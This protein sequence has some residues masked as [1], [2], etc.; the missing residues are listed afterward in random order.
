VLVAV[1]LL[2]LTVL[3][4]LAKPNQTAAVAGIPTP[5]WADTA[6]GKIIANAQEEVASGNDEHNFINPSV[7]ADNAGTSFALFY[8]DSNQGKLK[9]QKFNAAGVRQWGN[10]GHDLQDSPGTGFFYA[11][12]DVS[13]GFFVAWVDGAPFP[14]AIHVNAAG[15]KTWGP[16][17]LSSGGGP[18]TGSLQTQVGF[19]GEA[20]KTIA[21]DGAGGF[22]FGWWSSNTGSYCGQRVD[23]NGSIHT[24]WADGVVLNANP[25]NGA[26]PQVVTDGAGG[27]IFAF[28]NTHPNFGTSNVM[29][30]HVDGDGVTQCGTGSF[31]APFPEQQNQFNGEEAVRLAPDGVG[32]AFVGWN[33]DVAGSDNHAYIQ[34]ID[35]DCVPTSPWGASTQLD[36]PLVIARSGDPLVHI[37]AADQLTIAAP[38][39]VSVTVDSTAGFP[40]FGDIKIGTTTFTY[41]SIDPTHF[42]LLAPPTFSGNDND[43]VE[44]VGKAIGTL[45]C[46][47][48]LADMVT[49]GEGG[50]VV[51]W[52]DGHNVDPR[53]QRV[54]A[55]GNELWAG[56]GPQEGVMVQGGCCSNRLPT[57][58][59]V[60]PGAASGDFLAVWQHDDFPVVRRFDRTTGVGEVDE[61]PLFGSGSFQTYSGA[62]PNGSGG[63]VAVARYGDCCVQW[64]IKVSSATSDGTRLW[65]SNGHIATAVTL[66]NRGQNQPLTATDASGNTFLVWGDG[67][68]NNSSNSDIYAQK[69]DR[70]GNKLWGA[71]DVAVTNAPGD[72]FHRKIFSDGTN[73]YVHWWDTGSQRPYVQKFD[74]DG[75]AQW[76]SGGVALTS[77]GTQCCASDLIS[78]GAGG[79]IGTWSDSHE[80]G[81]FDIPYLQRVDTNG[82]L[83]WS[84][85]GV[86]VT[87]P[88][89]PGF[90]K[91]SMLRM[92][93]DGSNGAFVT[94][95]DDRTGF[96]FCGE[97]VWFQHFDQGG[98]PQLATDGVPV[99]AGP[100]NEHAPQIVTD[101]ASGAIVVWEDFRFDPAADLFA[102][103]MDA[104]GNI[105][106]PLVP[107]P[108]GVPVVLAPGPQNLQDFLGSIVSDDAGGAVIG[109]RDFRNNCCS[110]EI[111][112]QRLAAVDGSQMWTPNGVAVFSGGGLDHQWDG[113]AA[114]G[115][116]GAVLASNYG[117]CCG[118]NND[119]YAT[120]LDA[121]TGAPSWGPILTVS[122]ATGDQFSGSV[123]KS[124]SFTV[125]WTTNIPG[126]QFVS[127][128]RLALP[129][130]IT[131]NRTVINNDGGTATA[132]NFPLF[133][134]GD[135]V[136]DGVPESLPADTYTV[137]ESGLPGTYTTVIDGD[138][139]AD[140]T[141]T[142]AEG[143]DKVCTI[144]NDDILISSGGGSH[145]PAVNNNPPG[146][147][148]EC[149]AQFQP[150]GVVVSD[151]TET[152]ATLKALGTFPGLSDPQNGIR[153][154]VGTGTSS[155]WL[156]HT[157]WITPNT[158]TP[159]TA[160]AL[161]VE[162]RTGNGTVCPPVAAKF[163]TAGTAPVNEN[164]NVNVNAPLPP[165]PPPTPPA[166]GVPIL[167]V[168]KHSV[169]PS[170]RGAWG[171]ASLATLALG[172]ITIVRSKNRRRKFAAGAAAAV[173]SFSLATPALHLSA[174]PP[175]LRA[176][177][178]IDY[179][180]TVANSGTIAAGNVAVSDPLSAKV[181]YVGGSLRIGGLPATDRE[182]RDAG[183]YDD[184]FRT[185]AAKIPSIAPG[186]S[187]NINFAV[188]INRGSR[189]SLRNK[190][191]LTFQGTSGEQLRIQDVA[192]T[193]DTYTG[194]SN[195]EEIIIDEPGFTLPFTRP[196]PP[197]PPVEAPPAKVVTVTTP[198][199]GSSTADRT[200]ALEGA[201][202]PGARVRVSCNGSVLGAATSGPGGSWQFTVPGDLPQGTTTCTAAAVSQAATVSFTVSTKTIVTEPKD[203]SSTANTSPTFRGSAIA[204]KKVT[205][206]VDSTPIGSSFADADGAWSVTPANPLAAGPHTFVARAGVRDS[207]AGTFTVTG[208]GVPPPAPADQRSWWEKFLDLFR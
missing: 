171:L 129:S 97:D 179:V 14:H 206:Y 37:A 125:A 205:V 81:N 95:A 152:R 155:G 7:V 118:G 108:G 65:G 52:D 196:A 146:T 51:S 77:F 201:A 75:V 136:D 177:A 32:G 91:V 135:P 101:G 128:Q 181:T 29:V 86:P 188:T 199:E 172:G 23:A 117:P 15:T 187:V 197:P 104:S 147:D 99:S 5:Q 116:H 153:F 200:P 80:T 191:F 169:R 126:D 13:G 42:F 70:L 55:E 193:T 18:C 68:N 131:V 194:E 176:G 195:D 19:G 139:A 100:W 36:G 182:D 49:D 89:F 111:F 4:S 142:I 112:A 64:N 148:L 124:G 44:Q 203:G 62:I 103:R 174:S 127:A 132:S 33:W 90:R 88:N 8:R 120:Q 83:L 72:Q 123:V 11:A 173:L 34:R 106:W 159:G 140:G 204:G 166:A 134:D 168:S 122:S 110:A 76:T 63:I 151:L 12:P 66:E 2:A 58:V 161:T 149:P 1:F 107:D 109:W 48:L 170:S 6:T 87:T 71:D 160:Y 45:C 21:P 167:T 113:I 27:G 121:A 175:R 189:G 92:I 186:A 41:T 185:L 143:E 114:D 78:D 180:I 16:N 20:V 30:N 94:W 85:D 96:C 61:H 138:C 208:P 31:V 56:T 164:A 137:S 39:P 60:S 69:L 57:I 184:E 67:R 162:R 202:P 145:S 38:P 156:D 50:V 22:L 133:I 102:Q 158:L 163:T 178:R 198:E 25:S 115:E 190:A 40:D 24:G 154:T 82:F 79:V 105:S 59:P 98:I 144:V 17:D 73:L 47:K 54:D 10:A 43:P 157:T 141:V 46:N 35:G 74:A 26:K 3:F 119:L 130:S 93:T 165:P 28:V 150:T 207:D 53:L 9:G 192:E 183:M 84:P